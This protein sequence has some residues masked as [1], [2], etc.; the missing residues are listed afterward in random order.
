MKKSKLIIVFCLAFAISTLLPMGSIAQAKTIELRLAHHMPANTL[1]GQHM[2]RW[3]DKVAA[4][5][6]GRL[7]IRIFPAGTL[8]SA[9]QLYDGVVTGSADLYCGWRYKPKKYEI[10]VVLPSWFTCSSETAMKVYDDLWEKYPE[11][12]KKEWEDLKVLWFE[13]SAPNYLISKKP[14][15]TLSDIK[16]QQIRVPSKEQAAFVKGW[17]ASPAFMSIGDF[18]IGLDKGTVDGAISLLRLIDDFKLGKKLPYA[19]LIP[20][21][22][23]TPCTIAMNKRSF[24]KLPADLKEILLKSAVWGK[25]DGMNMWKDWNE[26]DL[27]YCRDHGIELITPPPDETAKIKEVL[28]V[29]KK[30]TAANLDKQ[31]FPGT[32]VLDFINERIAYYEGQ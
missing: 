13:P 20:S 24:K 6:D 10:G 11:L 4:D 9:P 15:Y 5:S 25:E 12:M 26:R 32:E 22:T 19:L 16:G 28:E 2:Q 31:G 3:A 8:L 21:G 18:V 1:L 29:E 30:V 27:K 7:K 23:S 17:G 14:L